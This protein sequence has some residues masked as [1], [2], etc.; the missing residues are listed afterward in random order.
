MVDGMPVPEELWSL[1]SHQQK[2]LHGYPVDQQVVVMVDG[3]PVPGELWSLGSHQQKL[4]HGCPV[5][6]RLL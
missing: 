1:G 4:L 6:N 5:T 3:M 2:L